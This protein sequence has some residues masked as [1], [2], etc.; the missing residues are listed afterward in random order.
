M[1]NDLQPTGGAQ[2][3]Q[4][5]EWYRHWWG[6]IIAILILP[7]FAIWY[8]WAK[9]NWNKAIKGIAT[10]LILVISII[11]VSS[12]ESGK[13]V[14]QVQPAQQ[15][16]ENQ[17]QPV[18]EVKQE[19]P[20]PQAVAKKIPY[21]VVDEWNIPNGGNGK[22]IVVSADF[23]NEVDMT[24]LGETLRDDVKND[25]NSFI[26]IHTDKKSA[27]IQKKSPSE[28]TDSE[29]AYAGKH[30]VGQYMKNA[31]SNINEFSIYLNGVD[32]VA[33]YKEIKY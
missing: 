14:G 33:K 24:L 12:N 27:Q 4:T 15:Q 16:T 3:D 29:L 10:F 17:D 11:T 5:K 1:D 13:N 2:N 21:E 32:D 30:F 7:I 18:Q 28:I 25:R 20:A 19:I 22:R 6:V 31:N 26:M 23:L 8:V 9:T